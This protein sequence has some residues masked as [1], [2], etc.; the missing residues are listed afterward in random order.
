[1]LLDEGTVD[2]RPTS[3][4]P[5]VPYTDAHPGEQYTEKRDLILFSH[6]IKDAM[7]QSDLFVSDYEVF[8]PSDPVM[9]F[10]D[11]VQRFWRGRIRVSEMDSFVP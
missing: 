4:R 3:H 9:G 10:L 6:Q 7:F 2:R 8:D 11:Y 5:A 1:M